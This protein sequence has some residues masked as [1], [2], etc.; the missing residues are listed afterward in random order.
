MV[1]HGVSNRGTIRNKN[2]PDLK[3]I[4]V[5][6]GADESRTAPMHFCCFYVQI[7]I[8]IG[9]MYGIYTYIWLFLMAKY[10]K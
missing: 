4:H 1:F 10:G 6:D 3:E 2:H 5:K 9:S 7:S 8:P